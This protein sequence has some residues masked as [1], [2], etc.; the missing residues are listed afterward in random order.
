MRCLTVNTRSKWDEKIDALIEHFKITPVTVALAQ[1]ANS[2][3]Y[4]T[5]EKATLLELPDDLPIYMVKFLT[6]K[7]IFENH[8]QTCHILS[9]DENLDR[10]CL[11]WKSRSYY[12]DDEV[13]MAKRDES[14][15][16]I[17]K[18]ENFNIMIHV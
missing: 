1:C 5:D 4:E 17:D 8:V 3:Y 12:W 11:F 2:F 10:L 14:T 16:M 18:T 15:A 6:K 9:M 7:S 13:H